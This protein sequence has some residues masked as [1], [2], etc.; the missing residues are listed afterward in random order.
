MGLLTVEGISKSFKS[1][2]VLKNISLDV[3][4]GER[5][6]II[7]PNGAGKTTLFNCITGA[8]AIDSG[9]VKIGEKVTSDLPLHQLVHLGMSRTF[10]KNNLFGQLSVEENIHLAI[11]SLKPY[12]FNPLKRLS[13]YRDLNKETEDLLRQWGISESGQQKVDNLSYGEQRILEILLAMA[14]HPRIL[15]LDEPTSGM[16]PAETKQTAELLQ[17]FPRSVTLLVVEHDMD[18]VFSIADKITVLHHGEVI[19]NG[20]PKD[21]RN[22]DKVQEI[23]FGGGG[24]RSCLMLKM[25]IRFM[26][27]AIFFREYPLLFLK[28]NALDF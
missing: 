22:S 23:Y 5:H 20:V 25:C 28:E 24:S 4:E 7:G 15:L 2:D 13:K 14:S 19:L 11:T 17:K 3:Q 9:V 18:V 1:L 16:S 21:V 10:Q 6:V 12:R 26:E 27:Q 8:L